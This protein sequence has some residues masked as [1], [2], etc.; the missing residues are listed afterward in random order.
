MRTLREKLAQGRFVV[1]VELEPPKGSSIAKALEYVG[2]LQQRVDAVNITDCPMANMR[3]SPI[4]VAHLLQ[5]ETGME[6]IFHLTCRDRNIIALQSDLL[7]AA[8]LGAVN[9]LALTGDL[10]SH[11]DHPGARGVFE[12]DSV[13]LV[14]IVSQLNRGLDVSGNQLNSSPSFLIGVA[15]N[16]CASDLEHE[17]YRLH[18]K[19]SGGAHFVQTQPVYDLDHLSLFLSKMGPIMQPVLVGILPLKSYKMTQHIINNVPGIHIPE[20]LERSM[21]SGGREEGLRVAQRL[22]IDAT[23]LASGAHLMPVGNASLV[24]TILEVYEPPVTAVCG[25]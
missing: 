3:M 18:E 19:L 5:K 7:G 20:W 22:L 12:V 10:P 16:P 6:A 8:A 24:S 2:M 25:Y 11:G 4:A 15:A 21:A 23:Q 17:C 1:T 14:N 13:G 9:I